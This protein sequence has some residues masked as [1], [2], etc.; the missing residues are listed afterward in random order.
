MDSENNDNLE[1]EEFNEEIDS[2]DFNDNSAIGY[3]PS[4]MGGFGRSIGSND[5]LRKTIE[6][7]KSM[8][9]PNRNVK[10]KD[11]NDDN[12][13]N[14][15]KSDKQNT[16]EKDNSSNNLNNDSNVVN[17]PEEDQSALGKLLNFKRPT[18]TRLR[19]IIIVV[20]VVAVLFLAFIILLG[21]S[22]IV[23]KLIG[24]DS[25]KSNDLTFSSVGDNSGF[26][27]PV[28]SSETTTR[29]GKTFASGQ[30]ALTAI[31]SEFSSNRCLGD[32][33]GAHYGIDVGSGGL[34]NV[35]NIIATKSGTVVNVSNDCEDNGGLNNS[36]N[37]GVGN[38]VTIDHGN[39]YYSRAQHMA[40]DSIVVSVGDS[41]EQ[42]Q[43][44]GKIGQ[45]GRCDGAHLHFQIHIGGTS[46]NY[47][48]D[49]TKY[50]DPSN[51]RPVLSS[52]SGS[53]ITK[54]IQFFEGTGKMSGDS[55]IAYNDTGGVL[56]VGHGVTIKYN[57]ARFTAHGI[58]PD[59]IGVG[60]KIP[61][62]VVD[63]IEAEIQQDMRNGVISVLNSNGITL[64]EHQI[65]ALLCRMYNTGNINS[66]PSNYKKYGDTD[67]LYNNYMASPVRDAKGNYL[68]GLAKRRSLE[69]K[70]FHEGIYTY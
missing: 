53:E 27:W 49:P 68:A 22:A 16:N 5:S 59:S 63:A 9:M 28:G 4:F 38:Y 35:Y 21:S 37:G 11:N 1:N 29:N 55:Y 20:I 12:D 41:V 32:K 24:S 51:P 6:K 13:N 61:I 58:N 19:L 56:T 57:R 14:D 46:N 52:G 34:I 43:V 40:K 26:W 60:T 3:S 44:I 66:F 8:N 17:E 39:G 69:W 62:S 31:S 30:P 54:M 18:G 70:L 25:D 7:N 67:A 45:S 48:V 23:L 47:A 50:I 15:G 65:D 36:C 10:P 42:G 2:Q 64:K 33:C